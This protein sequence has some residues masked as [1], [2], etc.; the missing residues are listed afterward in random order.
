VLYEIGQDGSVK[1]RR[2]YDKDIKREVY[3]LH[4]LGAFQSSKVLDDR[5]LQELTGAES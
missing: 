4:N 5:L 1:V 3:N 2:K